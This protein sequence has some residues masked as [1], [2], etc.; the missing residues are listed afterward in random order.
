MFNIYYLRTV[1]VRAIILSVGIT[2]LSVSATTIFA[3]DIVIVKDTK[4]SSTK[5]LV[6]T[7]TSMSKTE[8]VIVTGRTKKTSERVSVHDLV[9]I[10]WD[11]EPV[12]L[13]IARR[14]ESDGRFQRAMDDYQKILK[15]LPAARSHL[16]TDVEY[17][18]ARLTAR[19]A[20]K[21]LA[22]A[23]DAIAKLNTFRK[24]HPLNYNTYDLLE[25]LGRSYLAKKDYDKAIRMFQQLQRVPKE[26]SAMRLAAQHSE[27]QI[28]LTIG[29]TEKAILLFD[30]VLKASNGSAELKQFT[31]KA[32]LG[33]AHCLQVDKKYRE[34]LKLLQ[35]V[36]QKTATDQQQFLA[37]AYLLQGDCYRGMQKK[38][39]ALL[40]YLHI[41]ILFS[42]QAEFHPKALYYLTKLWKE[43]G[44]PI[45]AKNAKKKLDQQYPSSQW[46][47]KN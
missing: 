17:A 12:H 20:V 7:V 30:T 18:I 16:R 14:T 29:E 6:G 4:K 35:N 46:A 28:L 37:A 27:A 47:K 23:D 34:A 42:N 11:G 3:D 13:K 15:E 36:I 21:K 22:K 19:M 1:V 44:K 32:T 31:S 40:A 10:Q 5:R 26:W 39:D 9:Q 24:T 43:F 33:K 38:K 8:I 45:R 41:D 25:H 2:V